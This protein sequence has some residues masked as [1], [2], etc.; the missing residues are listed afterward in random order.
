MLY[1]RDCTPVGVIVVV[2]AI[3]VIL[4]AQF[5]GAIARESIL[6][7]PRKGSPLSCS[8]SNPQTPPRLPTL[9]PLLGRVLRLPPSQ[10]CA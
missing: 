2:S 3:T 6:G 5:T 7:R 8:V 10:P 1:R 9:W 4:V